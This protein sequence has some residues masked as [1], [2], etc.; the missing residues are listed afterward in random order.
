MDRS[1]NFLRVQ[2][3]TFWFLI[4]LFLPQS[5]AQLMLLLL[6]KE[7]NE[8]SNYNSVLDI[9][10]Q[11]DAQ[12]NIYIFASDV[13][14]SVWYRRF[15]RFFIRNFKHILSCWCIS[16]LCVFVFLIQRV[17]IVRNISIFGLKYRSK[18]KCKKANLLFTIC[19]LKQSIFA[20]NLVVQSFHLKHIQSQTN[21]RQIL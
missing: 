17:K 1:V 9:S 10:K 14:P 7:I 12:I 5:C 2:V 15:L 3:E 18:L 6:Q 4:S 13:S 20:S 21:I 8:L 11:E 19:S 16:W